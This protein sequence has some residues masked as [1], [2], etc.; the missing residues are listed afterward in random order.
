M[1]ALPVP[2]RGSEPAGSVSGASS[3]RLHY[4]RVKMGYGAGGGGGGTYDVSF[5]VLDLPQIDAGREGGFD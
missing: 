2:M 3:G 4:A 1:R 5:E